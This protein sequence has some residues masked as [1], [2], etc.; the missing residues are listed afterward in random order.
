MRKLKY[1]LRYNKYVYLILAILVLILSF[2][3]TKS[4]ILTSQYDADVE[5]IEGIIED[6]YIDGDKLTLTLK[7]K[8]K[9]IVNY[10][11]KDKQEK[12]YYQSYLR[13]GDKYEVNGN[14]KEVNSSTIPNTFDY[15]KYLYYKKIFYLFDA[16]KLVL[17]KENS[18]ILYS[19]KD[20]V[21]SRISNIDNSNYLFTFILGDKRSM[22]KEIYQS[23]QTLGLS[24]LFSISG[25][26]ITLFT[27]TILYILKK[28]SYKRVLNYSILIFIVLFY[29]FLTSFTASVVRS[30][31]F[32]ILLAL[33]KIFKLQ[34]KT[35][36]IMF[37]LLIILLLYN[38]FYIYDLGFQFSY[39]IS[40]VL[41]ILSKKLSEYKNYFL[42]LLAVSSISF[43]VSFPIVIYNFYQIN[44]LSVIYNLLYV[45]FVSF[46]IFPLT[47][48]TFIFP[49]CSGL[50]SF[51]II[52]LENLTLFL[53]NINYFNI[54]ISKPDV[55]LIIVY[56]IFIIFTL[57]NYKNVILF[58]VVVFF[59][60]LSVYYEENMNIIFLDVG[61]GDS[62]LI[63]YPHNEMNI[64]I[65]TGGIFNYSKEDWQL[66]SGIY[67][68]V[69]SKTI[70]YLKSLGIEKL[71]YLILTHGDNDHMGESI[72]L[73]NN[74][75]VKT[76][77]LNDGNV[78]ELE[79]NLINVLKEKNINYIFSLKS[80]DNKIYS[81]NNNCTSMDENTCSIVLYL[82][83][84][85]KKIL[86]MGDA[87]KEKELEIINNY[88]LK[89]IDILKVGHHGSKTS[90]DLSFIKQI[91][92]INSIISVGLNNRYNHPSR[93][94][95]DNL[96][97][98][99]IYQTSLDGSIIVTIN[100]KK[101]TIIPYKHN[102]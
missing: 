17:I 94:V 75:N 102:I 64:L 72:F 18:N 70:V 8:E 33:N 68:I 32:F 40:L 46:I 97:L 86:L 87:P 56:Y 57:Y 88:S 37:I 15:K 83:Y 76:V 1:I 29:M 98:S 43:L 7:S 92:P 4:I 66:R 67:S 82:E 34:V 14:I 41:I 84:F 26:H 42:K 47:I 38:P 59:H 21:R 20:F 63:R 52:I 11:F 22:D 65:D 77:V 2:V 53:S 48:L 39:L 60:K 101:L 28:V 62:I 27:T 19:I 50:L 91:N 100:E 10:Y 45:P 69:K 96:A 71:D 99:N 35:V 30:G 6:Y 12:D 16:S 25:M 80:I 51:F 3:Y 13:L 36:N 54:I 90:S 79:N 78:N 49:F 23:Y 81:L 9:I 44:I 73:V 5:C 24:H 58:V 74:F 93:E 95:L 89:N 85:N 61:Q 31:L 55:L